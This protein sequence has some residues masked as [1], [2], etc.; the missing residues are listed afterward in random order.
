MIYAMMQ[1]GFTINIGAVIIS[2]IKK[3]FFHQGHRYGLSGLL[4]HV[5]NSH[6]IE[7]EALNEIS[8]VNTYPTDMARI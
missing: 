7:K 4:T 1:K 6:D 3:A 5:L 2:A 8:V